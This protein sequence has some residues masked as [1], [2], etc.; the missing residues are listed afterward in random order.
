MTEKDR[1]FTD[2]LEE[3]SYNTGFTDGLLFNLIKQ[4]IQFGIFC[5]VTIF[6]T[7]YHRKYISAIFLGISMMIFYNIIQK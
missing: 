7:L 2:F 3:N 1:D 5:T 6:N 4:L